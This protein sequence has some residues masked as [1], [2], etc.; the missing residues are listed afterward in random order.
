MQRFGN[1]LFVFPFF[2]SDF[3]YIR[4][5]GKEGVNLIRNC[6]MIHFHFIYV[7]IF[8]ELEKQNDI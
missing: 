7:F 5:S 8:V 6:N 4:F 1:I 2:F 3:N